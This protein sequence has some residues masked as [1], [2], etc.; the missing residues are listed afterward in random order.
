MENSPPKSSTSFP[1]ID[2]SSQSPSPQT[3]RRTKS[4]SSSRNPIPSPNKVKYFFQD[5]HRESKHALGN[6]K[7]KLAQMFGDCGR[8]MRRAS[9]EEREPFVD[10]D[11]KDVSGNYGSADMAGC[12]KT[13]TATQSRKA[14]V[15]N[16]RVQKPSCAVNLLNV[17]RWLR[18]RHQWVYQILNDWTSFCQSNTEWVNCCT[19]VYDSQNNFTF[20]LCRSRQTIVDIFY[21]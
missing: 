12:C 11:E 8:R 3:K 7:T 21:N 2:N 6:K 20:E 9:S 13:E 4:L 14:S 19:E 5:L 1:Q 18:Y 15:V 10:M 17:L 16:S